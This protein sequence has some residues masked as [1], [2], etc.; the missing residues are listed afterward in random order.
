MATQLILKRNV[1]V[2]GKAGAGKS[3]VANKILG[4]STFKVSSSLGSETKSVK[5]SEVRVICSGNVEYT[6]K[7]ID[8]VGIFDTKRRNDDVMKEIKDFFMSK[9]P[10]GVNLVMFLF[11]RGR[12]TTEEKETFYYIIENFKK[13]I[14]DI[15]AL[16]MTGFESL[17][18]DGRK[19]EIEEFK[20]N[21]LTKDVAA[22]MGKGIYAIGFPN[23]QGMKPK[24]RIAVEEDMEEDVEILRKVVRG[25]GEMRLSKEVFEMSFWEKLKQCTIL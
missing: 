12:F 5:H 25:A 21:H 24:V 4:Q 11:K 10:E 7:V 22:F 17:D 16:V 9:V 1:V 13:E 6:F 23:T 15:S 20:R 18:D 2:L 14:K 8:T 19:R 3:T